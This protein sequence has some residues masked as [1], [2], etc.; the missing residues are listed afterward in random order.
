[1]WKPH[2]EMVILYEILNYVRNYGTIWSFFHN[3]IF[4][5]LTTVM[6]QT[7]VWDDNVLNFHECLKPEFTFGSPLTIFLCKNSDHLTGFIVKVTLRHENLWNL[8]KFLKYVRTNWTLWTIF[9]LSR[10]IPLFDKSYGVN[11]IVKWQFVIFS[12]ICSN[13]NLLLDHFELFL[14]QRIWSFDKSY[15][16]NWH[17]NFSILYVFWK[18]LKNKQTYGTLWTIF[19]NKKYHFLTNLMG[20][21]CV[22]ILLINSF[23]FQ[24]LI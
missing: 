11:H 7:T 9:F 15:C 10:T 14:I 2:S 8:F 13:L 21:C 18:Y 19:Y 4:Q 16:E 17:D 22:E 20:L 6:V 5:F 1:M 3:E 23:T 12:W 24:K